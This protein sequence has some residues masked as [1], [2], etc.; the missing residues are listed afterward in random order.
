[1]QLCSFWI[2]RLPIGLQRATCLGWVR[3]S[4][5]RRVVDYKYSRETAPAVRGLKCLKGLKGQRSQNVV[6]VSGL[7]IC[8]YTVSGKVLVQVPNHEADWPRGHCL[9]HLWRFFWY[10]FSAFWLRL[11]L[12]PACGIDSCIVESIL[13]SL[14]EIWSVDCF[15]CT[16]FAFLHIVLFIGPPVR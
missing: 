2:L 6:V 9:A 7:L 3:K 13:C 12:L 1:M 15:I 10:R 14:G 16:N 8:R 4:R 5:P 11:R